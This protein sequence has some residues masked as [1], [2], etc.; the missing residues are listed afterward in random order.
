MGMLPYLQP[1]PTQSLSHH[2]GSHAPYQEQY[3]E[4][5]GIN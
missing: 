4:T 1:P 5:C 3:Y 2:F